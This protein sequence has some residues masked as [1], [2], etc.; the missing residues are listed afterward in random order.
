M[1]STCS[2]LSQAGQHFGTRRGVGHGLFGEGLE[3][4]FLQEHGVDV[5]ADDHAQGALITELRVEGEAE[6]GEECAGL[7]DVLHRQVD[8]DLLMHGMSL[9]WVVEVRDA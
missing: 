1:L 9:F 6:A 3:V 4:G 7:A 5:L 8:V 2:R